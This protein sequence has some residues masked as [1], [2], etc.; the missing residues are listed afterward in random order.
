MTT[1]VTFSTSAGTCTAP[2]VGATGT[3]SC[4]LG[5][6][7]SGAAATV[8]MTV[9]DSAAA[10]S[11]LRDTGRAASNTPDPN[12]KNNAVTLQTTVD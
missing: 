6:L 5:N 4:K 10:G 9:K 7:A 8:T 1:F 3:L 12:T 11:T 2:A